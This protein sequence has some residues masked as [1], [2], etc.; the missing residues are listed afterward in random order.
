MK[1]GEFSDDKFFSFE[2]S[3]LHLSFGKG[4]KAVEFILLTGKDTLIFLEAKT[5][6][7]NAANKDESVDKSQKFE[8]Y[9]SDIADKFD[10]SFQMFLA[11]V[12]KRK[13]LTTGIGKEILIK[14]DYSKTS[15]LFVLVIRT[16]LNEEWLAGPKA[17]LEHRLFR[18]RKIWGIKVLVLNEELAGKYGLIAK[19]DV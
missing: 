13:T 14:T 2:N 7:P 6:C 17:E 9:Y 10:H 12:L 1:F 15:F 8:E 11:T 19:P 16:A 18:Y 5:S 4:L 3:P